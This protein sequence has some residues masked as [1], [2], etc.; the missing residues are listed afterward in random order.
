MSHHLEECE[1]SRGVAAAMLQNIDFQRRSYK[2][3]SQVSEYSFLDD[4]EKC[5]SKEDRGQLLNGDL[6]DSPSLILVIPLSDAELGIHSLIFFELI[7]LNL[8]RGFILLQL[9]S[10]PV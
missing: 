5:K 4:R 8:W 9:L 3:A 2:I 10:T 7:F 1:F 6:G